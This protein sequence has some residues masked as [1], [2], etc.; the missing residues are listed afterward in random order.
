[1]KRSIL[2]WLV[3]LM[4]LVTCLPM[5]MAEE[6]PT[7]ITVAGYMFGPIDNELDV[8]TPAVEKVLNEKYGLNVDIEVVYIEYGEY[9]EIL[10]PRIAAGTAPDVFLAMSD[11]TLQDYYDQGAIA[12]WDVDF[13]RE[14]APDVCAFVEGGGVG[15]DLIDQVDKWWDA[16]TAKDGKMITVPSLKPDGSMPYKTLVMR[17]DWL[18]KLGVTEEALPKTVDEFVDL[19]YRFTNE[20]PDGDGE[21]DTYG[22][23][24]TGVKALFGAY[25][26]Y[27]GFIGGTSYWYEK[28]GEVLNPDVSDESK[29]VVSILAKMYADG[30]ID[31]EFVTGTEAVAGSYWAIS[32]GLVNARY[33]ASALASIDHFR[34]KEVLGDNG[35]PVAQEYWAVNG[36]DATFVYAPWPAGPSGDYGYCVG[37]AVAVSE[38]P[39]YNAALNDDPEKLAKIFKIMNAFAVDDELWTLAAYGIEGEHYTVSED[40]TIVRN[41]DMTNADLNAVGVWGCRSLYGADRAYSEFSYNTLFYNDKSIAN[42]LNWFK[43][44]QYNSYIQNA[45][46]AVLPSAGDLQSELNTYR[47][48]TWI[49]MI[50]GDVSIEDGWADYVATY[51]DLGGE[52][53]YNEANEWYNNK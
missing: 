49:S 12:S 2:C 17:G 53:L 35:G 27:C 40:G 22:M 15:G 47:D 33:G 19:M 16:A 23:S 46:T 20:D 10:N 18:D 41:G 32:N 1:M 52:Q 37:E 42:R 44:D 24:A 11:S 45:V 25:G 29:E 39:V 3:A 9:S 38:S 4:L 31:P 14:N 43:K 51:M 21:A 36:D 28:D 5:A 13:F 30:V 8:V 7:K 34:L 6:A 50:K 26:Q 48:E